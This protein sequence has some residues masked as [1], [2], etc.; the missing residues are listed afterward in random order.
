MTLL[1]RGVTYFRQVPLYNDGLFAYALRF[2]AIAHGTSNLQTLKRI[3]E[4]C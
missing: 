4:D 3:L 1:E 2:K